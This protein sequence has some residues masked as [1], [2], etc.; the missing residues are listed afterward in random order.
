[1][2]SGNDLRLRMYFTLILSFAIGFGIIYA[3]LLYLGI[4]FSFIVVFAIAFFAIEW[5]ISP[6]I[7]RMASKL[8]Y[9]GDEEYPQLHST[10]IGLAKSANVPVPRIAIA[11]AKEPNAF[12]F[13][14]TRKSAT[15]VVHEGLLS[16]LDADELRAVLA[17]EIGHLRHNDVVVMTLVAFIPMLAFMLAQNILWAGMFGVE[18]RGNGSY[19]FLFGMLAFVVYFIAELLMLSLSRARE[20]YADE[21]SARTTKKPENLASALYKIT[22]RNVKSTAASQ[23]AT[24]ARTLYIVD[25][26]SADKDVKELKAHFDEVKAMLPNVNIN[27]LI[28][29]SKGRHNTAFNILNSMFATHP[30]AYKRVIDLARIKKSL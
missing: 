18:N 2:V 13:G 27:A 29:D 24:V 3:L 10:V 6:H 21:Y 11:P 20:S 23:N 1:M 15:L 7:L 25:F 4:G 5:Y 9:I 30:P 26:F 19:I 14:R 17:H 16:I 12:V 8:H 22:A 28:E